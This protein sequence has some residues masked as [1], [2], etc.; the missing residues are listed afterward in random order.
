MGLRFDFGSST[1]APQEL[2]DFIKRQRENPAPFVRSFDAP[3]V[4]PKK[5]NKGSIVVVGVGGSNL[6][7]LAIYQALRPKKKIYFAETLDARRLERILDKIDHPATIL[8]VSKSGTTTETAANAA[9]LLAN[10]KKDD[11]VIV[12]T[13]G[14][15]K[16]WKWAEANGFDAIA[17]PKEIGG[18]YSVFTPVGLVPLALAGVKTD[19]LL[20]GAKEITAACLSYDVSQNPAA[21][22]ALAIWKNWKDGK[23][24][25]DSFFFEPDLE[26]VGKWYRQLTGES[27]GKMG[28]GITPTV[29]V[30]T[31]DLHSVAQLY[32]DGP[33]DKFTTF[34][35]VADHGRD[36]VVRSKENIDQ[37]VPHI[38]GK[39]FGGIMAAIL[40]A[41]KTTYRE[42]NLPFM[43][44]ELTDISE[45]TL[46]A[47]LQVKMMEM[48]YLGKLMGVNPFD[49]PG[50]DRYKEETR[51]LL[52]DL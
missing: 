25:H 19:L 7:A 31:T 20:K 26:G 28:K 5:K 47:L 2:I 24:I 27:V 23:L 12:I 11:Q 46:G 50:V 18:R 17:T 30:G 4:L 16:L 44:M 42:Q 52:S 49:N 37:L 48:M 8:I 51:R 35:S 14:G 6:G 9:V 10:R 33:K 36:F 38:T 22:S 15:S 3:V 1:Q 45:E 32:L 41:V 29:S 34:V 39:T 13:D 43:S 40:T 21:Q